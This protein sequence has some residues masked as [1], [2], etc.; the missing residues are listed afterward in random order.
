MR[1]PA[2]ARTSQRYSTTYSTTLIPTSGLGFQRSSVVGLMVVRSN[3]SR[4]VRRSVVNFRTPHNQIIL[5]AEEVTWTS[6]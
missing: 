4:N 3:P 6:R 1:L 2:A 5:S